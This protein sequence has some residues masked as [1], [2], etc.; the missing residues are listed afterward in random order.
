MDSAWGWGNEPYRSGL[1]GRPTGVA[2]SVGV[3]CRPPQQEG[4]A[5]AFLKQL[6]KSSNSQALV[7]MGDFTYADICWKDNTTVLKQSTNFDAH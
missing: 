6:E 1:V 3:C 4:E 7:F 2:G 5:E